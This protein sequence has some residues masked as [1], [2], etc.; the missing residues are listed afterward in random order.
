MVNV[1]LRGEGEGIPTPI[2]ERN[3]ESFLHGADLLT[4]SALG[5][6]ARLGRPRKTTGVTEVAEDLEALDMHG[7]ESAFRHPMIPRLNV[8]KLFDPDGSSFRW[9]R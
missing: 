2:D 4:H 3:A 6:S 5:D 7:A 8:S 9:I 1:S